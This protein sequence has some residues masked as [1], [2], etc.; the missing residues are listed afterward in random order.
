MQRSPG[1]TLR[2]REFLKKAAEAGASAYLIKPPE[3]PKMERAITVALARHGDLMESRR[4]NAELALRNEELE[5]ARAKIK[6]LK[7]LLPICSFCKKIRSDDGSWQEVEVY[8]QDHSESK[9]SHSYCP[10]CVK[11]HYPDIHN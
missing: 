7:G 4:L 5:K 2:R 10:D 6:T 3:G 11:E 1:Q 8:V 9:F